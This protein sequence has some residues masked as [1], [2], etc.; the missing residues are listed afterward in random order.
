MSSMT[1][2]PLPPGVYWR[3]RVFVLLLA[4]TV[5]F[6]VASLLRGGSDGESDDAPVAQQAGAQVDASETYTVTPKGGKDRKPRRERRR[7]RQTGPTLGPSYDPNVLVEP[8]GPCEVT[9]VAITPRVEEAVRGR[10]VTIGLSL[11]STGSP[12]CTWRLSPS[13]AVVRISSGGEEVW[14]SR[15]CPKAIPEQSV[16]V[17]DVVATVVELAWDTKESDEGCATRSA[18]WLPAGDYTVAAAAIGGEPGQVD[19]ELV[20]PTPETVTP[21]S[22]EPGADAEPG[23]EEP[24]RERGDRRRH[25][26]D[27]EVPIR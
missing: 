16:I 1:R 17:R 21:E 8:E 4:A 5:I 19:F 14:T 27:H 3:R 9:D 25:Q 20:D 2:G 26:R 10:D 24:D 22:E 23:A 18:H 6:L 13:R 12:A 11:Q 15:E 7:D